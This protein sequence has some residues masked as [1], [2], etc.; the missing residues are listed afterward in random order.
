MKL[1]AKKLIDLLDLFNHWRSSFFYKTRS[2]KNSLLKVL[3]FL[4]KELYFYGAVVYPIQIHR[5]KAVNESKIY[6]SLS[7]EINDE[8]FHCQSFYPPELDLQETVAHDPTFY[9]RRLWTQTNWRVTKKSD[10]SK[11]IQQ[12]RT[13]IIR[14]MARAPAKLY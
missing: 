10:E 6:V 2:T 9:E 4:Y 14:P 13:Y 1:P 11:V 3:N 7:V 12:E 8:Q 5:I